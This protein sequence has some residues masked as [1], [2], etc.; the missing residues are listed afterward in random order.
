MRRFLLAGFLALGACSSDGPTVVAGDGGVPD[1]STDDGGSCE[2]YATTVCR[3]GDLHWADSCGTVLESRQ[4]CLQNELCLDGRPMCCTAPVA[5]G[6]FEPPKFP[7][8]I[9]SDFD[10]RAAVHEID[11]EIL[12]APQGANFVEFGHWIAWSSYVDGHQ[13]Y[14]GLQSTISNGEGVR[15]GPG[16]LFSMFEAGL[17]AAEVEAAPGGF[18]VIDPGFVS[19]RLEHTWGAGDYT[20]RFERTTEENGR[21]RF[22]AT[23]VNKDTLN[24]TFLGAILF[25][26][27]AAQ[28]PGT[29]SDTGNLLYAQIYYSKDGYNYGFVPK[30]HY[31]ASARADGRPMIKASWSAGTEGAG[32]VV[33]PPFPNLDVF[34]NQIDGVIDI[35]F[36]GNTPNCSDPGLL[37]E[38]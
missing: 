15:V 36:G 33:V 22:A 17:T 31:R 1:A 13:F 30:L 7:Y 29:L 27:E 4:E 32:E 3:E 8:L 6:V 28:T 24:E 14:V 21:D 2:P 16:S 10:V 25:A 38:E 11:L 20:L 26:R 18:E 23:L 9:Y 35:S 37:F 34:Y 12:E 19:A 5:T